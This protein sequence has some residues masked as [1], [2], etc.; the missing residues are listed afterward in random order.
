MSPLVLFPVVPMDDL[1]SENEK[2]EHAIIVKD[3]GYHEKQV[4]SR[5]MA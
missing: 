5:Y 1:N 3:K 4:I 2:E